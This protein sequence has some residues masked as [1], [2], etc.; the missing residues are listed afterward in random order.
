MTREVVGAEPPDTAR[1]PM[2]IVF[3]LGELTHQS[4][5]LSAP[6]V[7]PISL[8]VRRFRP[9]SWRLGLVLV[10]VIAL[11]TAA[12]WHLGADRVESRQA[13]LTQAHPPA[14]AW[15]TFMGST[16]DEASGQPHIVLDL[17]V[18]NLGS[19]ELRVHS[20]ISR[21]SRGAAT[22]TLR[23]NDTVVA[24]PGETAHRIVDVG[25]QCS[26]AYS[27]A[28]L[29]IDLQLGAP[30]LDVTSAQV[31]TVDDGSIGVPYAEVLQT[32]CTKSPPVFGDGGVNGIY[33]QQ[34][35]HAEAAVLVLT[36]HATLPRH[37]HF[38]T[39]ETDGF[40]LHTT[41]RGDRV[42]GPGR[43]VSVLLTF[44]V[45][46]CR[47]VGR[48]TNYAQGVTLQVKPTSE[49]GS[50]PAARAVVSELGL[51]ESLL[52]PLGAAVQKACH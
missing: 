38:A 28:S 3:D 52:A 30:G 36:N 21:T 9:P 6:P 16:D 10:T 49:G 32:L 18:M 34:T 11:A 39:S 1:E 26:S 31:N 24:A 15:L 5:T 47:D 50:A 29:Q 17:N 8:R 7:E 23:P 37:V 42:L 48:L 35:S 43:S 20:V 2:V 45:S 51:G 33:V 46:D 41:P 40:V 4:E 12:G 19:T 22:A 14:L 25:G 13:A 27:G 44:T